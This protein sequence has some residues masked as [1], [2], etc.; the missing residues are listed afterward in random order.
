M[1][2]ADAVSHEYPLLTGTYN[3][4]HYL[5]AYGNRHIEENTVRKI[6]FIAWNKLLKCRDAL[7]QEWEEKA[8]GE[9]LLARFRVVDFMELTEHARPIQELNVDLML[10]T[11]DYVKVYESGVVVT[12]FLDGT[13]IEYKAE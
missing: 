11:L 1:E 5:T 12:V 7:L 9:D 8:Q 6:Y 4:R 10:R 3:C 13:E 2:G